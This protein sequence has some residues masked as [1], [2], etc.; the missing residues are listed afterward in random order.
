M[1]TEKVAGFCEVMRRLSPGLSEIIRSFSPVHYTANL[2]AL[3][4]QRALR[5]ALHH[6]VPKPKK[7]QP[8]RNKGQTHI[9][10]L[11]NFT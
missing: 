1:E 7:S 2:R 3:I 6:S 4:K 11:A 9:L 10:P 8:Q 5:S